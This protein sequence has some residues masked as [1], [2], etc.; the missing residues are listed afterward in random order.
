M[1]TDLTKVQHA[2]DM[3][4]TAM[5]QG[6]SGGERLADYYHT[7][8]VCNGIGA[9]WFPGWLRWAVTK[10]NPTLEPTSWVHDMEYKEG[11]GIKER[12]LADWHWLRNGWRAAV[13]TYG[14]K[15]AGR[16]VVI[17][18]ATL[19]WG[20]LRVGGQAAFNWRKG[21]EDNGRA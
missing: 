9:E 6:L 18:K 1:T 4:L 19:F 8:E 5:M 2:Y 21:G 17:G 3:Y 16:Y 14:W 7:A 20:I 13:K 12:W 15:E 10:T 11:G